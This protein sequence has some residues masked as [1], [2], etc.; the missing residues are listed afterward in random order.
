M[1]NTTKQNRK[2]LIKVILQKE[3]DYSFL[4]TLSRYDPEKISGDTHLDAYQFHESVLG[5]F[6]SDECAKSYDF[7]CKDSD[8]ISGV[9]NEEIYRLNRQL[10][11]KQFEI[12]KELMNESDE[13]T[14]QDAMSSFTDKDS[15][16]ERQD[17]LIAFFRRLDF[18]NEVRI[19]YPEK[20]FHLVPED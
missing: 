7:F 6:K 5:Y 13:K 8:L 15:V 3:F 14:K 1:K 2:E 4:E 18:F 19:F 20:D 17:K 10:L 12:V 11:P 9:V 16:E